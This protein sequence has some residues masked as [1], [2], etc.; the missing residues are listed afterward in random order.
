MLVYVIKVVFI[1]KIIHLIVG[2]TIEIC[3]LSKMFDRLAASKNIA[4]PTFFARV[5]Q[6]N[7]LNFFKNITQQI[8][9]IFACQ[10]MFDRLATFP[11][12]LV[13]HFFYF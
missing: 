2:Q 10:A 5:K 7:F 11:T 4:R 6:K 1:W 8:V 3:L 12:L 9:L 13:K